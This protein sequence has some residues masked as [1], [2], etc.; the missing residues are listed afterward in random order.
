M[1]KTIFTRA[2]SLVLA[3]AMCFTVAIVPVNAALPEDDNDVII[4]P[5]NI[6][7]TTT[8]NSFVLT[9]V[10]TKTVECY[11]ATTVQQGYNAKVTVELQRSVTGGWDTEKTWTDT[12]TY[13]ASVYKTPSVSSGTYRLKL[14][15]VALN[16]AGTSVV[17]TII[18]YSDVVTVP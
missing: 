7:I 14:T 13:S 4:Q 12:G 5:Y 10:S 3:S 15:H 11:G 6:A 1:R 16:S 8:S 2:A 9:N 18:K 17:E